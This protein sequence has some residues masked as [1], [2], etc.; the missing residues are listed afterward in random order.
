MDNVKNCDSS[1]KPIEQILFYII[2]HY[3]NTMVL[4]LN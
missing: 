1:H 2:K 3:N 4:T